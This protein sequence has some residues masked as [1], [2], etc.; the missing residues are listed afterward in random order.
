MIVKAWK[1]NLHRRTG[2]TYGVRLKDTGDRDRHFQRKWTWVTVELEGSDTSADITISPAFWRDCP[3]LR[4]SAIRD[5][6]WHRGLAPWADHSPPD[7]V[8]MP[9]AGNAFSLRVAPAED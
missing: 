6:L 2:T 1:N 7:L 8:L 9:L 4:S 5:W 3:E